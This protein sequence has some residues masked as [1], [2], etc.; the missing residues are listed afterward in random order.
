MLTRKPNTSRTLAWTTFEQNLETL[1]RLNEVGLREAKLG[2]RR[3]TKTRALIRETISVLP[4][5][6]SAIALLKKVAKSTDSI[7]SSLKWFSAIGPWQVVILVTCVEA[8]LQDVLEAAAAID[9]ELMAKS[10][11]TA[12]YADVMAA[13]SLD[14]LA[15]DMRRMWASKWL[16]DGGPTRWLERLERMGARG[17][18]SDLKEKL[19]L[20]WG[21]RHATVHRAGVATPDFVRRHPGAV[22]AIGNRIKVGQKQLSE[23]VHATISMLEPIE[24]YFL[25]RYPALAV[26]PNQ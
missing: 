2:Y 11:Q 24:R 22:K 17:F 21:I 23:Y 15:T 8:Y 18:P 4:D 12:L 13:L 9:P 7:G 19:E 1:V 26:A 10:E 5:S 6:S 14:E 16:S 25:S 20:I 3:V